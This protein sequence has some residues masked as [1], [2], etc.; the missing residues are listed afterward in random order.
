MNK[1]ESINHQEFAPAIKIE[2]LQTAEEIE[3]FLR[4][5][6]EIFKTDWGSEGI[7][8]EYL[9][10]NIISDQ[11]KGK[12][13]IFAVRNERGE[14][15]AGARVALLQKRTE[16]RLGLDEG[17]SKFRRGAL[18]EYVVCEI[19]ICNPISVYSKLKEEV[20]F[21]I[22]GVKG[23]GAG[24]S[25]PYFVV[26]KSISPS[27]PIF[28]KNDFDESCEPVRVKIKELNTKIPKE[29][30]KKEVDELFLSLGDLF[31]EGWVAIEAS[32]PEIGEDGCHSCDLVFKKMK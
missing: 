10:G 24:I 27:F 13:Q 4:I 25:E 22:V 3:E 1:F 8:K 17:L 19:D 14:I 20:G 32:K 23:P 12:T 7:P 15:I 16:S 21:K 6:Y 18:L 5:A 31:R 2:M 29:Q 26:L 30:L 28:T 11:E 9:L